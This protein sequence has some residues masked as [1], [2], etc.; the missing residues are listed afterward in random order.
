MSNNPIHAL[1]VRN[2]T[3]AYN[4]QPVILNVTCSVPPGV[5]CALIGPNG[6]GKT[7]LLK[8]TVGLIKPITGNI[9]LLGFPHTKVRSLVAYV[10]QRSTVDWDFPATVFDVVMMGRYQHIGWFRWPSKED[11]IL[12]EAA[13]KAVDMSAHAERPIGQLSGGQQQRIFLAR[14]LVQDADLYLMDEP[15]VGVDIATE[16]LIVAL[17]KRLRSQGK[18]IIVVHHDLQTARLYFDWGIFINR[19]LV[20]HGPLDRIFTDEHINMTYRKTAESISS[21]IQKESHDI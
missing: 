13:L 12:V 7:S 20:T 16:H 14:A 2:V 21:A 19:S 5:M 17:L 15:F 1:D 3:L 9:K 4:N 8:A 10:P 6:A 18:T 11:Q